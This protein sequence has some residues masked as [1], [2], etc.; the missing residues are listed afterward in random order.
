MQ[1]RKY[2]G[3]VPR[4]ER[5]FIVRCAKLAAD[6]ETRSRSTVAPA[7]GG[8][9]PTRAHG[10]TPDKFLL[11]KRLR[12]GRPYKCALIRELLWDWFVDIRRS[13][14]TR[15]SPKFMLLKAREISGTILREQRRLGVFEPLPALDKHWLYRFKRDKGIV[16]RKPNLRFKC[17]K[18]T[19]LGRLRAM[20]L[21]LFRVRRL[22]QHCFGKELANSIWGVDEKPIHFNESGSKAVRTLEIAGAPAVR[23]KE[24]HAA[25]RERVSIMTAVTSSPLDATAAALPIELLFK[26]KSQKRTSKLALPSGIRI[27]VQWAEKGSYRQPN[28]LRYLRQWLA[29]WTPEREASA[30][31]R[32]LLMDVAASHVHDEVVDLAW[33]RGYVVLWHYGCTTGVAQVNDTDCHGAFERIYI[34]LEQ[35]SFNHQQLSEPGSVARRP[36]DVVD[37]VA[38]TWRALPHEQGRLGHFR[39]G[40]SVRLDGSQDHMLTREAGALWAALDMPGLRAAALAEVDVKWKTGAIKS[41]ADWRELIQH[42]PDPGVVADEGAEFEGELEPGELPY[43]EEADVAELERLD[44]QLAEQEFRPRSDLGVEVVPVG[45][46][47]AQPATCRAIQRLNTL[48]RLRADAADAKVPAAY[49]NLD[50]EVT[51]LERGIRSGTKKKEVDMALRVAVEAAAAKEAEALQQKRFDALQER[52][53]KLKVAA[54][55]ARAKA[56]AECEKKKKVALQAKLDALPVTFIEKDLGAPGPAGFKARTEIL[57]RLHLRSPALDEEREA[58]WLALRNTYAKYMLQA[59]GGA[60]GRVVIE[61]VNLVLSKLVEHYRGKTTY[62][63]KGEKGGNPGAF[64]EF[65]KHIESRLPKKSAS[66]VS[67]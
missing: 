9:R 42:P 56:A 36:Q 28:I 60:V 45:P 14:E 58:K 66:I 11:R 62:N 30:D 10:A 47:P 35:T 59:Y 46:A 21:N 34:E 50:R 20:W 32:I 54:A 1:F 23:L 13:L 6:E 27:S 64:L 63:A 48:K 4:K 22:A 5:H 8:K 55:N 25:T 7:C 17:S 67:M 38:A 65:F 24:N 16:F 61:Q 57:E 2:Q 18:E 37:D 26:A 44:A 53:N 19:L 15:I 39:N 40:L 12:Q 31:Y 51:Q 49:F 41:F 43:L 33:S 29:P 52:R 3:Q